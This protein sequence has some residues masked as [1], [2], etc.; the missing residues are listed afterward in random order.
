MWA[1]GSLVSTVADMNRFLAALRG[2]RLLPPAVMAQMSQTVPTDPANPPL[3]WSGIRWG[4]GVMSGPLPCGGRWWGHPG[5]APGYSNI[6]GIAPDGRSASV[7]INENPETQQ[8]ED[9]ELNVIHT[10]LCESR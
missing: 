5:D 4:L 7:T 6:I 1:A 3:G 9:A 2:G 8:A 10:A